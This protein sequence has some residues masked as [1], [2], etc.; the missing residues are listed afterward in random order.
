[1]CIFVRV[2]FFLLV[3]CNMKDWPGVISKVTIVNGGTGYFVMNDVATKGG[4][5]SQSGPYNC[6]INITSIG[7]DRSVVSVEVANGGVGYSNGDIL[8]IMDGD[9]NCTLVVE[10]FD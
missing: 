4:T 1:M 8:V 10:V 3:F 6:K 5:G 2:I 9:R 7:K